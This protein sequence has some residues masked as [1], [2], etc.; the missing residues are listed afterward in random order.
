MDAL[1]R[2][3]GAEAS[4]L[5]LTMSVTDRSNLAHNVGF[6]AHANQA[7]VGRTLLKH[8]EEE[9]AKNGQDPD[10]ED[11]HRS[12]DNGETDS[13]QIEVPEGDASAGTLSNLPSNLPT[14]IP[15]TNTL[16]QATPITESGP[17]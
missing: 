11:S 14:D 8:Q 13:Q 3:D 9:A 1:N 2:G 17:Q 6:K 10:D 7:E 16:Q 12:D 5:W 4:Q 15:V